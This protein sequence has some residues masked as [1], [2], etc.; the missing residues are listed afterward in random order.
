VTGFDQ[1]HPGI[2]HH[3][4]NSLGWS[5]LR[6][7]QEEAVGPILAGEHVLA[8]APTAGG[9]T[10]A[11]VFPLLS[12]I[13][14][15]GWRGLSVVYVCPLRALVNNLYPRLE[16]Y[17]GFVGLRAGLWHGDVGAAARSRIFDDPPEILL[18]T[19]ESLEAILMSTRRDHAVFFSGLRSIVVDEI[20]AF[21]GDDRGWHLLAVIE[22]LSAVAGRDLQRIG[23][24]ATVG[25]PETLL[26][27]LVGSSTGPAR[28][29]APD[30]TATAAGADV[31]LD[32]VGS[33][34]NAGTVISRLH[35]GEK[36]LVFCDSRARVEELAVDLRQRG[37]NTFV[38]HSSLALDER[39]RAEEAFVEASDCVIVA[40][41]TLELGVDVGDLDRVIQIDS[42][43]TVA[44]FLQRLGRSGRRAGTTRN[45]LFLTTKPEL[46]LAQAAGLL[47]LWA[48]GYVEPVTAPAQPYHLLA[49]QVLALTLQEGSLARP[50]WADIVGRLPAFAEIVESGVGQ[51]ILEHLVEHEMLFDEGHG[52]L[53]MGPRGERSYGYRHFLDLT[54]A[55]TSNPLFVIRHGSKEIGYLDPI[56]LLTNDRH[57]ASVLLAGRV[58]R[59]TSIDWDR[60][61]AWVEP[62]EGGGRS[63]WLGDGR[64]LSAELCDSIR[65]VLAGADPAGVT[66]TARASSALEEIR[67][68]FQWARSGRTA[69]VR[70][71]KDLS[72][73]TFAG[74]HA[75]AA[76]MAAMGPLLGR[77]KA[78]NLAIRLDPDAATV[79]RVRDFA[80]LLDPLTMPIPWIAEQLASKLKFS[81]CLPEEIALSI[82]S[83]RV[84]DLSGIRRAVAEPIDSVA[85]EAPAGDQFRH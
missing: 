69:V 82:A 31:T 17:A 42:P 61:F 7:L 67:S 81:D 21:G 47:R 28:V 22:R 41:S 63:R 77:S 18:T 2:Q 23:L 35:A 30:S 6:P 79:E 49:Q 20:H 9:K 15:E 72:W 39:R 16:R 59:V 45:L 8:L 46:Q 84:A 3:V 1:L 70:T 78:D 50:R 74:L 85:V 33:L 64:P 32:Y 26:R 44:G 24:S 56:A 55:F 51:R 25:E 66:L 14:T 80:E 11:A 52:I 37:V 4:V 76:L 75:N 43:T 34:A 38:S 27:W 13:V 10:E 19:P 54:S 62:V 60:R 53:S 58:W 73:W 48:R 83:T 12:R 40:T 57:L 36:R 68:S 71:E 5:F 65:D 29:I